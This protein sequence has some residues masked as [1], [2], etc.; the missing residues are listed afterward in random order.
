MNCARIMD[1]FLGHSPEDVKSLSHAIFPRETHRFSLIMNNKTYYHVMHLVIYI[2]N[3]MW[4]ILSIENA[5][6]FP[7]QYT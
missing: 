4:E 7:P 6:S 2:F 3:V 5:I 1:L